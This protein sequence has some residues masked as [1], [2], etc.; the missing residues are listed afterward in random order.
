MR[1][2]KENMNVGVRRFPF[3]KKRMDQVMEQN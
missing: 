3:E 2:R 1:E